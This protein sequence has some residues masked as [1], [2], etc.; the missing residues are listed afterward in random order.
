MLKIV[1]VNSN[2][3]LGRGSEYVNI[4]FDS[5]WRNIDDK[6]EFQFICFSDRLDEY[7]TE[8][9]IVKPLP[10]DLKGWWNK[11]WLFKEGQFD[12]EDRIIYF[13]LD[14]VIT[15]DLTELLSYQGDF[16]ILRDIYRPNGLQSSVMAWNGSWGKHI[17]NEFEAYGRPDM[18]GGDQA[19]IE[20]HVLKVDKLQDLYPNFFA[21]FKAQCGLMYPK[22]AKVVFFHGLPRPHEVTEG[23]VPHVWKIGGGLVSELVTHCNT[24]EDKIGSNIY[25]SSQLDLE[26]LDSS[27]IHDKH[28]LI[29][30]GGPS[31]KDDIEE[32]RT[33]QQHGQVIFAVNGVW[34]VLNKH[35]IQADYHVMA[36]AR[37]E[38]AQ[39]VPRGF[40]TCLYASQC[41]PDV[42][43]KARTKDVILWHPFHHG[44]ADVIG[45]DRDYALIGGGSTVGLQSMVIAYVMGFRHLH[46]FGMDSSY[47]DGEGHAYQQDLNNGERLL[48]VKVGDKYFITAPWM[49]TQVD[50]FKEVAV[51]LVQEGCEIHVHGS[52]LLPYVA[53]L[54]EEQEIVP[55]SLP[56]DQR[57]QSVLER[58]QSM[59][60]PIG[61]EV[62]VFT[63][64]LSKRLLNRPDLK[65][66]MVDSWA[67]HGNDSEYAKSGDY[68]GNLS[69]KEQDDL[70][71]HTVSVTSF[72]GDRAKVIRKDSLDAASDFEDGTLD[73]VFLD[74]DHTYEAIKA[75]IAAWHPKVKTG[76][77]I[78]GHDYDN[79]DYPAWGV[80]KA[81]DELGTP[82]LGLNFTWFIKKETKYG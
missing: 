47:R 53:G 25:S 34:N 26:W 48:D 73:F 32:I 71:R 39:F 16:S 79:V 52:G 3:Y 12:P 55:K 5:V 35:G 54:M 60:N 22:G 20:A 28:A 58:L 66:F 11:L 61:V 9:V 18:N 33:R 31:L 46:I 44:I 8:G 1:C 51:N 63:G 75:D 80:K 30:G 29:V 62:G 4:L 70:Y 37:A 19:W 23:F 10:G 67:E 49:A 57:A 64:E 13:D 6:T 2:N 7:Y 68:H 24:P 41:H 17:W 21:S 43:K 38:N 77:Y 65:L 40:P 56:A 42:F 82:E 14:T 76:G 36:D 81:V 15:G 50:Q 69:K 72:A 74:A 45:T 59:E 78:S 27:D